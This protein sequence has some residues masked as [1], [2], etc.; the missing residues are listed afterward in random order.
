[1][2]VIVIDLGVSFN[3]LIA[4]D[5]VGRLGWVYALLQPVTSSIPVPPP[6][7]QN[8]LDVSARRIESVYEGC[9]TGTGYGSCAIHV[10]CAAC[11]SA[12]FLVS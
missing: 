3:W 1:M 11:G 10:I 12:R 5:E 2:Y 9:R 8:C 4:S 7:I 6:L